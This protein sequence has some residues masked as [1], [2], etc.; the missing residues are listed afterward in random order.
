MKQQ[1]QQLMQSALDALHKQGIFS[2]PLDKQPMIERPGR[3]NY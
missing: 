2:E 3:K 1:I